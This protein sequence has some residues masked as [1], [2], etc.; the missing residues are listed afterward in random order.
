MKSKLAVS[1]SVGFMNAE[2]SSEDEEYISMDP[3]YAPVAPDEEDKEEIKE[4][5]QEKEK[6]K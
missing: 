3:I 1:Q 4:K 2:R 6:R 5:E